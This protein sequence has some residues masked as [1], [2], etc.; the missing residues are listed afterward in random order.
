MK[1]H[2]TQKSKLNNPER[3]QIELY[4]GVSSIHQ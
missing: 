3:V 1:K 2:I 4:V